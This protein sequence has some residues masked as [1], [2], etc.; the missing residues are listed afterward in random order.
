MFWIKKSIFILLLFVST[1]AFAKWGYYLIDLTKLT[2]AEGQ[3][4]VNQLN[5][6][7]NNRYSNL[8]YYIINGTDTLH[9]TRAIA[10]VQTEVETEA[11][12]KSLIDGGTAWRI[13]EAE[14]IEKDGVR[15]VKRT[16]LFDYLHSA[17]SWYWV[18]VN[19]STP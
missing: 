17:T 8:N 5:L 18:N 7:T 15:T 1:F 12:A 9:S 3:D 13:I 6:A 16:E 4:L 2:E 14:Y 10:E 11:W 19:V